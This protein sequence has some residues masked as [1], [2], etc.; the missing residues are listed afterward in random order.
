MAAI[1]HLPSGQLLE[2]VDAQIEGIHVPDDCLIVGSIIKADQREQYYDGSGLAARSEIILSCDGS[3]S[4]TA[5]D[6]RMISGMPPGSWVRINNVLTLAE[7]G[8]IAISRDE[9][10]SVVIEAAGAYKSAPLILRVLP[11]DAIK[12]TL[13]SSIDRQVAEIRKLYITTIEGQEA[14]YL[15]K[16]MEA[17]AWTEGA[18]P[19]AFPYITKEA[20]RKGVSIADLVAEILA[21]A[22]PWNDINS[23]LESIRTAGKDAV[24]AATTASEAQAAHDAADFS[25]FHP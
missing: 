9:D 19:S 18:D 4:M 23:D 11:L 21:T 25:A 14:T 20:A 13:R 8:D 1:V 16:E 10:G 2:L 22:T 12:E 6:T 5:G 17:R 3:R 24:S 7:H 15:K